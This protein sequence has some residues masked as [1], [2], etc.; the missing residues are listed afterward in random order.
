MYLN[1]VIYYKITN[2]YISFTVVEIL[3]VTINIEDVNDENPV[4]QN[5]PAEMIA[6]VGY[7]ALKGT[8]VYQLQASDPDRGSKIRYDILSGK[9]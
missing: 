7:N 8:K 2:T 9:S 1:N 3:S 4:F 5:I 6:T